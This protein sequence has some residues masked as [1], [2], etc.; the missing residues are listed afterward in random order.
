MY[1]YSHCNALLARLF[2]VDSHNIYD[3]DYSELSKVR[4]SIEEIDKP[5][6]GMVGT[7][8]GDVEKKVKSFKDIMEQQ[9][10]DEIEDS[11]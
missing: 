11:F 5:V 1:V 4:V 10:K 2:A 6:R 3:Y 7:T 8:V 9:L